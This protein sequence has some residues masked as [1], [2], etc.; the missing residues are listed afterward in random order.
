MIEARVLYDSGHAAGF[1]ESRQAVRRGI[2]QEL[3]YRGERLMLKLKGETESRYE[4]LA[5][6]EEIAQEI[7]VRFNYSGQKETDKKKFSEL[8]RIAQKY[9]NKIVGISIR[10][11]NKSW[12]S[13][14]L[15]KISFIS[16]LPQLRYLKIRGPFAG[17]LPDLSKN[18][19]LVSLYLTGI[20][21]NI[22]LLDLGLYNENLKKITLNDM[23]VIGDLSDLLPLSKKIEV[24]DFW[25]TG[26]TGDLSVLSNM[27]M[28]KKLDAS[29]TEVTGDLSVLSKNPELKTVSLYNTG[30]TGEKSDLPEVTVYK[31]SLG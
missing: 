17:K 26:V 27:I 16:E 22:N 18:P 1:E 9:G 14:E 30:V 28:L 24:L 3:R 19:E 11:L 21:A 5:G 25:S 10:N 13:A 6:M 7:G 29:Y 20:E 8:E 31:N 2:F 12:E 4:F 15:G 23:R